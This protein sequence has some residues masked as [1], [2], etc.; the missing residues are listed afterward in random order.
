VERGPRWA[1]DKPLPFRGCGHLTQDALSSISEGRT[2]L[3]IA[4]RLSTIVESDVI[5][6]LEHGRIAEA[7]THD[8]LLARGGLYARLW[9]LQGAAR[10]EEGRDGE[11]G[12]RDDGAMGQVPEVAA[13][14]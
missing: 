7:G 1:R 6:V 3:V 9:S 11:T 8:E 4:H 2:T 5:Y 14:I 10:E 12:R 13:A